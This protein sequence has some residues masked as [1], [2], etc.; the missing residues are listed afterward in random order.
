MTPHDLKAYGREP[1]MPRGLVNL[2]L[3]LVALIAVLAAYALVAD[4]QDRKV[5]T[6]TLTTNEYAEALERARRQGEADAF[7]RMRACDWRDSFRSEPPLKKW[8]RT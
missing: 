2:C 8:S 6:L 4:E 1:S 3:G 7:K 5:V